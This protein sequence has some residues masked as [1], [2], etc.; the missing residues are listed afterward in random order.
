[1]IHLHDDNPQRVEQM[2]EYLYTLQVP[3]LAR[4]SQAQS[5]Y[6]IADKYGLQALKDASC[7]VMCAKVDQDCHNFHSMAS[8]DK[9]ELLSIVG[10]IWSWK[11]SDTV[12]FHEAILRGFITSASVTMVDKQFQDFMWEHKPF[13][14]LFMRNALRGDGWI[15]THQT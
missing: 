4:V 2:L 1:M 3:H 15:E 5:A 11:F 6:I 10:Q 14:I 13:G 12:K 8:D 9:A 7:E